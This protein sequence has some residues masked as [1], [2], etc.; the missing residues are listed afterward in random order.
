MDIEKAV[1]QAEYFLLDM[2]GTVYVDETPIGDMKNTL[3]K[4]RQAGKKIIFLTNN[5]SKSI[6]TYQEKLKRIDLFSCKDDVY[7][8]GTACGE[9]LAKNHKGDSVYLVGT[10]SLKKEFLSM[11]INLVD[12][13]Q[14]DVAVLAFDTGMDYEKIKNFNKYLVKGA[15]YIA[16]HP[17]TVCPAPEVSVPDVGSFIK[18]FECSSGRLPDVIIGKPYTDMGISVLNRYSTQKEKV[19]MVGDR[20]HTDIAFGLNCGFHTLLVLSGETTKEILSS[21]SIKPENVLPSL[22]DVVKYL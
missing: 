12:G 19:I 13:V 11:G 6:E 2:D 22:N 4:I 20:L 7:S 15:K 8:S 16:T 5:S 18:M 21:S 10:D 14:P 17:D 9:Y 3:D 1:K